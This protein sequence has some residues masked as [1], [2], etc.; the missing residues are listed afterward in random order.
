[1]NWTLDRAFF[2]F[3]VGLYIL[4]VGLGFAAA[5]YETLAPGW[6]EFSDEF[7]RLVER[8]FGELGE[9]AQIAAFTI[10]IAGILW[11][12]VAAFGL[13]KFRRWSRW[14]FL[15]SE[16]LLILLIFIP[17]VGHPL[18]LGP[19]SNLVEGVR[20]G[21]FAA[22]ILLAYSREHGTEWFKSPLETLK[23][24]F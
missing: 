6:S 12:L 16:I 17:V 5:A 13:R 24:T 22:V 7:D 21:L 2:R 23:D 4:S 10:V 9:S 3:L 14:N 11:N 20:V 15:L 18:Y 19:S 8:H 1:M